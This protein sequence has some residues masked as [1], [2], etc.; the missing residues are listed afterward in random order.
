MPLISIILP[1]YNTEKYVRESIES[2]LGQTYPNIEI[3]CIND[4][5]TDQS[6]EMLRSFGDRIVIVD[7]PENSGIAAARNAGL[8]ISR[9]EFIAFADADDIWKPEK[10]EL[11]MKQFEQDPNLDISFCMIQNFI[12]PEL[13]ADMKATL[14]CPTNAMPGQISG[15]VV[16]KKTSF[17]TIGELNPTYRVGEFIDWMARA[18][19]AGLKSAMIDQV[20]YLR[21]MHATNTTNNRPAQADYLKIVKSALDRKRA[22]AGN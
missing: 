1:V 7:L 20:L 10:L 15:T 18:N 19:E 8:G 4:G 9:G 21:R 3:I 14:H 12:S 17:D 13:S 6:L 5:S 11:Q 16:I 2:I 22:A